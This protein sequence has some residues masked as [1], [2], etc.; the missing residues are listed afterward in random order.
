MNGTPPPKNGN[1]KLPFWVAALL[2]PPLLGLGFGWVTT[3][4]G[5]LVNHPERI[6]VIE[7]QLKDTRDELR[8]INQKLDTIL[9]TMRRP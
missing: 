1:G 4:N 8:N 9:T 7:S 6:A 5:R 3:S 2:G